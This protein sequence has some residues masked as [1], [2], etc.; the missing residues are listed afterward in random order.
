MNTMNNFNPAIYN[1]VVQSGGNISD[2]EV[3]FSK[4]GFE[5]FMFN[6]VNCVQT[7]QETVRSEALEEFT[8][9][10][11]DVP[12]TIMIQE[13]FNSINDLVK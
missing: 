2:D 10:G 3:K 1:L 6:V 9:M 7:R 4:V 12:S 8:Y 11:D 5:N 13:V